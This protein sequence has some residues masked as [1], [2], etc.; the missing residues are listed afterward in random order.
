[1]WHSLFH[2]TVWAERLRIYDF[3]W[4]RAPKGWG[5][6]AEKVMRLQMHATDPDLLE[7]RLASAQSKGCIRIPASLNT[8]ID[9]Y[10]ILDAN[11]ELAAA[12]GRRF[13]VLSPD[14]EPTPWSGRYLVVVDSNRQTRPRWSP[15]P[16][17]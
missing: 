2:F 15:A 6:H 1:M 12:S 10:G 5:D 8:F 17:K 14:R 4:V 13:F 9:H 3:G 11:Y 16:V 7:R